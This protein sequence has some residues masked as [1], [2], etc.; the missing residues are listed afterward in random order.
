MQQIKQFLQGKKT[1]L[2]A[3]LIALVACLGWWFKVIGY[4]EALSLLGVAGAMAG[5]GA[6]SERTAGA[7]LAVLDDIQ[8][9]QAKVPPGQ[10]I[11]TKQLVDDIGKSLLAK[12][13]QGGMVRSTPA[14][15]VSNV[16][17]LSEPITRLVPDEERGSA[18]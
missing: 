1:Y 4:T 3:A 11:D 18:K 2:S 5:L 15:A 8:Q 7:I 14:G 6:K 10:K 12:F 13:A 17:P 9:A 16:V